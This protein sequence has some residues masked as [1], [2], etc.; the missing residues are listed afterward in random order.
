[1][2]RFQPIFELL[3][4]L[5][6]KKHVFVA[7][8]AAY[9]VGSVVSNLML[10]VVLKDLLDGFDQLSWPMLHRGWLLLG[11][12]I[13]GGPV[14]MGLSKYLFGL[15]I[16]ETLAEMR[17]AL[18]TKGSRLSSGY[19]DRHGVSE[20]GS[21]L[22]ND[23]NLIGQTLSAYLPGMFAAV[24]GLI[25]SLALLVYWNIQTLL[26][27]LAFT[28]VGLWANASFAQRVQRI[29]SKEQE[30]VS[31]VMGESHGAH[32]GR[33]VVKSLQAEE[34]FLQRFQQ[35]LSE[36]YRIVKNRGI[37]QGMLTAVRWASMSVFASL[38][39][40]ISGAL[41]LQGYMTVGTSQGIAQ[42]GS[43]VSSPATQLGSGWSE[44]HSSVAAS[45]RINEILQADEADPVQRIERITQKAADEAAVRCQKLNFTYP[46]GEQ[47]V[48]VDC[49][50]EV[51]RGEV[52]ALVGES[53]S[54]KSTIFKLLLGFYTDFAGDIQLGG[55]MLQAITA[56]GDV[57][58]SFCPQDLQLFRTSVRD[59]LQMVL[60]EGP[61]ACDEESE[62]YQSCGAEVKRI[63]EHFHLPA[64]VKELNSGWDTSSEQL[65]GG[66][67][68]R[69]AVVRA[70][71]AGAPLI[72][73]D[74]PTSHLDVDNEY[75]IYEGI[76][77]L[78]EK[79][80]VIMT[81]HRVVNLDWVDSIVVVDQ[82]KVV[83]EGS[84]SELRSRPGKFSEFYESQ[85]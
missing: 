38:L 42:L 63:M 39:S 16:Q 24:V 29:R 10:A 41:A 51:D 14:L 52:V 7:A 37:I 28:A 3:S 6:T 36:H 48:L 76:K 57:G 84:F 27:V 30:Q 82:G 61:T 64:M 47:P 2:D 43:Q 71:L 73:L 31:R 62:W 8:I 83:Q 66:Q 77:R 4:W 19:H 53:G 58:I 67:R 70:F 26:L 81:T 74:E 79:H 15:S 21:S 9:I 78:A 34:R 25:A 18:F 33:L 40:V 69:V 17:E 59:N 1:M 72:L 20:L 5:R 80:T 85:R 50:F 45:E 44:L 32:E 60:L 13:L 35:T 22:I 54:G 23:I 12:M 68:Q 56:A 55:E 75:L 11:I 46:Q 65:S 49:S